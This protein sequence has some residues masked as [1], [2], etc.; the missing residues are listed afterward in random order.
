MDAR[1]R[2]S[3]SVATLIAVALFSFPAAAQQPETGISPAAEAGLAALLTL[4]I[5]GGLIALA[6]GYTDRTTRRVL[7]EPGRT[8]IYG[9]LV[10][11]GTVIAVVVLFIIVIGIP[12]AIILLVLVIVLA[13]IGYLATG[14][15]V[16]ESW[17][18]ALL[19]A[20][21]VAAFVGGVPYL[22]GFVGLVVSSLGIGAA[23]IEYTDD[24]SPGSD[25]PDNSDGP[26]H[27]RGSTSLREP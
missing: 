26:G 14:R 25:R 1:P 8:F 19:I 12:V 20:I 21:G 4:V 9:F 6:P 15:A 24:G 17:G 10:S 2:P 3:I 13:E 16:S 5:G 18:T 22:G 23:V 7:D 11:I 27:A